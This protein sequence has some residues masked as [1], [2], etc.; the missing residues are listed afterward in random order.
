MYNIK[1]KKEGSRESFAQ[2]SRTIPS[3][4]EQRALNC[5]AA[6]HFLLLLLFIILY[7]SDIFICIR[8]I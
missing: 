8:R 7:S 1:R 3:E 5:P 2:S 6:V 4:Y